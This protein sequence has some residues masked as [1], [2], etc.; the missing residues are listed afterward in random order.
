MQPTQTDVLLP[1]F[2]VCCT[3]VFLKVCLSSNKTTIKIS[4]TINTY[5]K[6]KLK[7]SYYAFWLFP[8]LLG[9]VILHFGACTT[10][11]KSSLNIFLFFGLDAVHVFVIALYVWAKYSN[12]HL[13]KW[14]TFEHECFHFFP[15]RLPLCPCSTLILLPL[16]GEPGQLLFS[17]VAIWR[18][19]KD[20]WEKFCRVSL[21]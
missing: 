2:V 16:D 11:T 4:A 18:L 9:G 10:T 12:L 21:T 5:G 13:W 17:I 20:V 1:H 15:F 19:K 8:F 14:A 6:L 7:R 3:L